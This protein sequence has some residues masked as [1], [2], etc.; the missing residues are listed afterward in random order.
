[1]RITGNSRKGQGRKSYASSAAPITPG[2]SPETAAT[3]ASGEGGKW[4]SF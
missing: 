3:A 1:M 2:R 4:I